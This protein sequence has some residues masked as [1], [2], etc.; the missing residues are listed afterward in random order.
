MVAVKRHHAASYSTC[1]RW[2]HAMPAGAPRAKAPR[3]PVPQKRTTAAVASKHETAT[4]RSAEQHKD[5]PVPQ[6]QW[7]AQA[8]K[9]CEGLPTDHG[10]QQRRGQ[11]SRPM[12]GWEGTKTDE[13]HCGSNRRYGPGDGEPRIDL[14]RI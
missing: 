4:R 12:A 5:G 11:T 14:S 8:P 7:V 1:R 10:V 3:E 6:V 2:A 13:E 9:I